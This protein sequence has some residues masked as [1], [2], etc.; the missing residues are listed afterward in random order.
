MTAYPN[1]IPRYRVLLHRA[2]VRWAVA[3]LFDPRD[4]WVGLSWDRYREGPTMS[5]DLYVGLLPSLKIRIS[6]SS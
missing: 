5:T 6:L 1:A 4:L 2:G 3:L